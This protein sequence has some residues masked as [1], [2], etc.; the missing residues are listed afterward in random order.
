MSIKYFFSLSLFVIVIFFVFSSTEVTAQQKVLII[1]IDGCRQDAL[2]SAFTPN[3]DD[4]IAEST[5]SYDALTEAPTWSGVGW[6]GMLTGVWRNKHGVSDNSF[7]ASNFS[8]YPHFMKRVEDFDSSLYT[9][10]ICHW[11]PVNTQ[12]VGSSSLNLISNPSS[13]SLVGAEAVHVLSTADPDVIFLHFDDVDHEGHSNGFSPAVPSY[14]AAIE[15]VDRH[16]GYVMTALKARADFS[17]EDWLIIG[18]TDHGGIGNSHGGSSFLERNIFFFASKPGQAATQI[19]KALV[20]SNSN[21]MQDSMGLRMTGNSDY[22]SVPNN[23]LF[24]FGTSQDFTIELRM[25]TAGWSGDPS[26]VG[27]KDW[28]SGFNNGFIFSAP[29]SGQSTWKVNIGDGFNRADITGSIIDDNLWHHLAA[30]FD[31]SGLLQLYKDGLP[32]GN[33]SISSVGDIDN[34]LALGIGQDGTLSYGSGMNGIISEVRIWKTIVDSATLAAWQCM[35]LNNT[36]PDYNDLVAY[37][38]MNDGSSTTLTD[39]G[40]NALHATYNGSSSDWELVNIPDT[41]YDYSNTP[42]IVDVAVTS[43]THLCIPV[44]P[45]WNLDGKAV[46]IPVLNPQVSGPL[47]PCEMTQESYTVTT[48]G[49]KPLNWSVSNGT[50][51]QGQDSTTVLVQWGS[52]GPGSVIID[53][54]NSKDTLDVIV[55]SCS[56]ISEVMRLKGFTVFPN[57]SDGTFIVKSLK[58]IKIKE[59][60]VFNATGKEILLLIQ[61][62]SETSVSIAPQPKGFYIISIRDSKGNVRN[63]KLMIR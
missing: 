38:Q 42:R 16:V 39:S 40:P 30:S 58:G 18:S 25:K 11:A 14:I 7:F 5:Y 48:A 4:L 2:Q 10:S 32:D 57:P 37:W 17:N 55:N 59:I 3:I 6:S 26:F 31:R 50:V 21:C 23:S 24:Q 20:I 54:C 61:N 43:L 15:A 19:S 45:A 53:Q 49:T 22:A 34:S 27:N 63:Q 1:G 13:D 33:T 62:S 12:I 29:G 28:A 47:N 35:P 46:G 44:N 60:R 36:H 9:V 51:V 56:G 52:A 41:S 8:A